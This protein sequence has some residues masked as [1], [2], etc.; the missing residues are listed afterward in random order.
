VIDLGGGKYRPN[1]IQ[2][3]GQ[4]YYNSALGTTTGAS[5]S[6]EFAVF[7]A[8]TFR[9]REVSVSFDLTGTMA[10]TKVFKDIRFTVF[11]RNLYYKA[12][13]SLIDPELSTLGAATSTTG[14][15]VR[16]L[17]L[18]SAPNTRNFG[19]SLRATF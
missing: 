3:S 12:P 5:T 17:E 10:H 1:N 18:V 9:L 6:N 13:N 14:G 4:T 11:G 19:A 8:T 15:L 7:D 16:G 2:I